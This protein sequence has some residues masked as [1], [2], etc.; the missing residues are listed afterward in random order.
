MATLT[1]GLSV[2]SLLLL[3]YLLLES[4]ESFQAFAGLKSE[5][6]VIM[7]SDPLEVKGSVYGTRGT[8]SMRPE[9]QCL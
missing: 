3:I 7:K 1:Q 4:R 6:Q 2:C 8:V 9:V 5:V